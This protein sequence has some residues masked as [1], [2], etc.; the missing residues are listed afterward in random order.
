MGW[1]YTSIEKSTTGY[2]LQLVV[3]M[4]TNCQVNNATLAFKNQQS[5]YAGLNGFTMGI[6]PLHKYIIGI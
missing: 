2:E 3:A 5:I 4:V 1:C 6:Y